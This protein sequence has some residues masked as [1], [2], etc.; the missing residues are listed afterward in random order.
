M[1]MKRIL[2]LAAGSLA[3]IV[4][5][6]ALVV[7][8]AAALARLATTLGADWFV[9]IHL[10]WA[11]ALIVLLRLAFRGALPIRWRI[12]GSAVIDAP[13]ERIWALIVPRPG[14]PYYSNSVVRI[15]PV[16]DDPN[17]VVL[18]FD[19]ALADPGETEGPGLDTV[20]AEQDTGKRLVLRYL[21]AETLPLM[22][23]DLV[24]S[25]ILIEPAGAG[26]LTVTFIEHMR[27]F[28]L[29]SVLVFLHLN[30]CDDAAAR[31][32]ALCEGSDDASWMGTTM[33]A[34]RDDPDATVAGGTREFF[35]A[36]AIVAV[37]AIGGVI[38]FTPMLFR[39]ISGL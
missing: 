9:G 19:A 6:V 26:G 14:Q 12:V 31:L 30:P 17:R 38:V 10:H 3:L 5:F 29:G 16:G 25:E 8:V 28:R 7:V 23:Q 33:D 36:A 34:I 32:K 22:G 27:A 1:S 35:V 20:I 39:V 4:G 2:T 11:L 18:R 21:N 15:E 13:R 37:A 24:A